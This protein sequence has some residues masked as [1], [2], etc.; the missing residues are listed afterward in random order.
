VSMINSN[1]HSAEAVC[2]EWGIEADGDRAE[3]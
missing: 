2:E 3:R 1:E